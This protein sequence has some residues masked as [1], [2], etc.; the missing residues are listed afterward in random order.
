MSYEHCEKHDK[1]A[2][3]GCPGCLAEEREKHLEELRLR[4]RTTLYAVVTAIKTTPDDLCGLCGPHYELGRLDERAAISWH[5]LDRV[6]ERV[7][8][9]WSDCAYCGKPYPRDPRVP[10]VVYC[11]LC[12]QN[13]VHSAE[14]RAR[15]AE[16]TLK[17]LEPPQ[18]RSVAP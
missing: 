1:D 14:A 8:V 4:D 11:T 18:G 5:E 2:T 13:S 15:K 17:A 16:A 6:D 10:V 3:S 9:L 7:V 12:L